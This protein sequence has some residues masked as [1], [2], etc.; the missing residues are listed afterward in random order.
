[1]RGMI[2]VL[3]VAALIGCAESTM[4]GSGCPN[5]ACPEALVRDDD[6]CTVTTI[7]AE[8]ATSDPS[9]VPAVVCLPQRLERAEDGLVS[10]RVYFVI[11]PD[12]LPQVECT[13][14]PFLKPVTA[15]IHDEIVAGYPGAEVCE[16]VQLPIVASGDGGA[17]VMGAGDGF[18]YDDFS[19]IAERECAKESPQRIAATAAAQPWE[20]VT[21]KLAIAEL[22]DA[23]G[24]VD[25]SLTCEPI[26]GTEPIGAA[27]SLAMTEYDDSQAIIATRSDDCGQGVCLAHHLHGRVGGE[28]ANATAPDASVG[29]ASVRD[30]SACADPDQIAERMYCTC[31]CDGPP[32]T[33]DL[34][35]CPDG[36]SCVD[37]VSA[38]VPEAEGAYCVRNGG[39]N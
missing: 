32:G 22:R 14:R 12:A 16:V 37:L 19:D 30:G 15:R 6:A 25:S 13:D 31:R 3:C 28:C 10:A 39:F 17:P 20:G 2:L 4:V 5:G 36:F 34:C 11:G 23:D 29:N 26:Q 21:L 38:L 27:C 1:M 33:A 18:Y 7:V 8:V 9:S 35:D 24:N